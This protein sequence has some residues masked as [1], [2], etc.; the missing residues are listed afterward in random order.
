MSHWADELELPDELR[1]LPD[2]K[3]SPDPATFVKR[4]ADTKSLVGRSLRV[5][6]EGASDE[7]INK[8]VTRVLES[9]VIKPDHVD[10]VPDDPSAYQ[11]ETDDES[12]QS[13]LKDRAKEY[14][15]AGI[16][17]RTAEKLLA[18]DK[19][20]RIAYL[21]SLQ[22]SA[23]QA[24]EA[25]K[26]MWEDP[27]AAL[28][29]VRK[30]AESIDALDGQ[31][32][33]TELLEAALTLPDGRQVSLSNY[34]RL[35][36]M[37]SKIGEGLGE[38]NTNANNMRG[39]PASKQTLEDLK[40]KVEVAMTKWSG[41]KESDPEKAIAARELARAEAEYDKARGIDLAGMTAEEMA[42]EF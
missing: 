38:D 37:L 23:N 6:G 16:G 41:L 39:K 13:F 36:D 28:E 15:E 10:P 31:P 20:Q 30:V 42:N 5:P 34:P 1:D 2:V 14:H 27:K 4:Y 8:F 22:A 32:A 24:T 25:L 21:E 3:E 35:L 26:G 33:F 19:E 40:E 17:K 29:N 12:L 18:R 9:N 7:D 11:V